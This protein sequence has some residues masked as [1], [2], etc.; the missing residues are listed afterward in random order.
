MGPSTLTYPRLPKQMWPRAAAPRASPTLVQGTIASS[1]IR[2]VRNYPPT[3]CV[4]CW[5]FV[6]WLV[7]LYVCH[8]ALGNDGSTQRHE[9]LYWFRP[10]PYVQSQR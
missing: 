3:W 2:R 4:N 10:E 8:A 1:T 9:E 5:C 6:D 7:N